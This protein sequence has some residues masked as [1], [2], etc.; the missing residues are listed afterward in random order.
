[1]PELKLNQVTDAETADFGW[2]WLYKVSGAAALIAGVLV[3]IAGID[4]ITTG[5]QPSTIYSWLSLFG[6]NWL[7]LLFK[8]HAGVNG[9]H[10]DH[11]YVLN[12][13]DIVIMVLVAT[14][15]LGLY[16]ALRR[17]SE[18]WSII[19]LT[20]PF[21][22]IVIFIATNSAGRSAVMGAMLV[23]SFVMLRSNTFSNATAYVGILASVLLLV[24]DVSVSIARSSIIAILI[25]IGYVLLIIWFFLVGR[26]LFHLGRGVSR[27]EVNQN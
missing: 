16:V 12:L 4:L 8:L 27:E 3:L 15:F 7:I 1:M 18:I 23:I 10:L 11:L 22:G 13:L 6:N 17:A 25:A 20:Q 21:L 2:N 24:G 26:R 14:M 5:L 9:V 19:A